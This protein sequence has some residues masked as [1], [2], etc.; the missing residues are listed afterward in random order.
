MRSD[1]RRVL[2]RL[3]ILLCVMP[4]LPGCAGGP[5]IETTL[6]ACSSL[7]P[8]EWAK[9]VSGADLPQGD[10]VAD[11]IAFGDAQTGRLDV[12]NDRYAAAVGIVQ[13]CEERDAK[14][15]KRR[16]LF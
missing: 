8:D 16:G 12:S 13:R 1:S 9:G 14:A 10:T 2:T 4:G 3:S 7:L 5:V 15:V 6:S 11:W